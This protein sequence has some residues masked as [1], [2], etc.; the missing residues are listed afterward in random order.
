MQRSK[1]SAKA[2][3]TPRQFEQYVFPLTRVRDSWCLT[4]LLPRLQATFTTRLDLIDSRIKD[5]T[6]ELQNRL[7]EDCEELREQIEKQV[8]R[9]RELKDKQEQNPC[10]SKRR[11]LDLRLLLA[12]IMDLLRADFYFC[13]DDPVAALENVEIAPDGMSDA[14]TAFTR[15]TANPTT[16]ASS[17]RRSS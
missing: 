8:D 10:A 17:T 3:S 14:G 13:I 1:R 11:S 4:I 9:L 16:L 12:L 2:T 15:Y 5:S 6:L 7:L